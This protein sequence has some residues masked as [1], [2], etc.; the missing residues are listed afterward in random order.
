MMHESVDI[1]RNQWLTSVNF[2]ALVHVEGDHYEF[3]VDPVQGALF[4]DGQAQKI[5]QA[6][7]E[8]FPQAT[9]SMT[10]QPPR[11]ETPDQRR[12]R[13]QEEARYGAK[14]AIEGDPLV[15]RVLNE[16]GGVV[17][18]ETIRPVS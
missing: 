9:V 10:L 3:D 18:D 6:L 4:N 14:Q 8:L 5:Q 12:Q 15:Q 2:S 16:F 17:V 13:Q 11:G 7:R 1:T